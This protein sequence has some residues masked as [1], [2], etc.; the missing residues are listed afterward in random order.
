M[1]ILLDAGH[2]GWLITPEHP[3]GHYPTPGKRS[4]KHEDGFI[5]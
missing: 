2:G 1:R 5:L 4:P 3:Q